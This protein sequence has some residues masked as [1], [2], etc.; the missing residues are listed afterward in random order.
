MKKILSTLLVG[1]VL[2][3]L[4]QKA[5][6]KFGDIPM[7]DIKMT[8]YE[9][10]SSA[11]AVILADYGESTMAYSEERGFYLKFERITRIKILKKEGLDWG[12]FIIPRC[13]LNTILKK[14]RPA[15]P[16]RCPVMAG[17]FSSV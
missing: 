7:E 5:P 6:I 17:D 16:S 2:F 9:K 13:L 1:S 11:S 10:D 4:A 15:R 8:L 12:D 14:S 3:C